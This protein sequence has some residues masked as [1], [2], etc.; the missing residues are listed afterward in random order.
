ML[1]HL[2][3][4]GELAEKSG[5]SVR[6]LHHYD[7]IGL[8]VPSERTESGHRLYALE[9]IARLHQ[10]ISLRNLGFSLKDTHEFLRNAD[11]SMLDIIRMQRQSIRERIRLQEELYQ[12]LKSMEKSIR[13]QGNV[14]LEEFLETI[15]VIVMSEDYN[16]TPE[17]IEK[18][19]QQGEVLGADKIKKGE[20][21]WPQLIAKVRREMEKGTSP[22]DPEVQE[23]AA[24]WR[25]LTEMFTGGDAG[26]ADTIKRRYKEQPNY[27]AQHGLDADIFEY[28]A[29]TGIWEK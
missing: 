16:F 29:K 24:R 3:K 14:T 23:L 5:V 4:V 1:K 2:L 17:Q 20:E 12:K 10:I 19:K 9:N 15:E 21:E 26:I 28:I 18:I 22:Q 7:K 13:L 25:E 6:S 27:A 8:L 11:V